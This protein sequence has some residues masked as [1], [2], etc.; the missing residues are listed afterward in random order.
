MS[1]KT[2]IIRFMSGIVGKSVVNPDS[3]H[4]QGALIGQ[5]YFWDEVEKYAKAQ[6]EK[7]WA[8]MEKEG[9]IPDIDTLDTGDHQ[10]ADS[11]SFSIIANVSSPVRRFKV[12][13]LG[14]LLAKSKYKVPVS[15][16]AELCD[17]AKVPG[18]PMPKL[19]II[20][21]S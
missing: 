12:E 14:A 7:A 6:S 3:K 8:T 15:V 11:P 16:T 13:E 18:N 2:D 17:K 4:N 9:V 10:L 1:F 19:K 5:A 21:R 20:E